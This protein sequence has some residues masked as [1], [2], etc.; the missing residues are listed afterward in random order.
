MTPEVDILKMPILSQNHPIRDDP[1]LNSLWLVERAGRS[2]KGGQNHGAGGW[3]RE[4]PDLCRIRRTLS[5]MRDNLPL[6]ILSISSPIRSLLILV[7]NADYV[8]R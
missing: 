6:I 5:I 3:R 8:P 7:A 4:D 2:T 1:M